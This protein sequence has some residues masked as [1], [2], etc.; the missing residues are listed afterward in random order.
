MKKFLERGAWFS[1]LCAGV[2]LMLTLLH[3]TSFLRADPPGTGTTASC[4]NPVRDSCPSEQTRFN[5]L[6]ATG[7]DAANGKYCECAYTDLPVF[8]CYCP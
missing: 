1:S 7:C 5:C 6:A 4:P 2:L 3:S 8:R